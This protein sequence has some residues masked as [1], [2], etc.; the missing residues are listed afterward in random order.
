MPGN[1]FERNIISRESD[2]KFYARALCS[3]ELLAID[4]HKKYPRNDL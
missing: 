4:Y 1:N 3:K 2:K